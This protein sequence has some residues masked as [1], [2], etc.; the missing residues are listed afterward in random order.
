MDAPLLES[1]EGSGVF[2]FNWRARADSYGAIFIREGLKRG[3]VGT[4]LQTQPWILNIIQLQLSD[5]LFFFSTGEV[6]EILATIGIHS[7]YHW[8]LFVPG[9]SCLGILWGPF[10]VLPVSQCW[11]F[12][13]RAEDTGLARVCCGSGWCRM[14]SDVPGRHRSVMRI[15]TLMWASH[16]GV[17]SFCLST[18]NPSDVSRRRCHINAFPF[19][20]GDKFES[21]F[22]PFLFSLVVQN[23]HMLHLLVYLFILFGAIHAGV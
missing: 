13:L 7:T 20:C 11:V 2:C 3:S 10:A 8:R 1:L 23:T 15:R 14:L 21:V 5:Q 17:C 18:R 19:S 4:A 22:V 6:D 12:D 16:T 9:I